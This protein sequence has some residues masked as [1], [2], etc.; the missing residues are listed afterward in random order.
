MGQGVVQQVLQGV[1]E[2]LGVDG[3]RRQIAHGVHRDL[4]APVLGPRPDRLHGRLEQCGRPLRPEPQ[5]GASVLQAG[6]VEQVV[7]HHQQPLGIV[8]GVDQQLE[9]L[10]GQRPDLLLQQQVQRQPDARQRGL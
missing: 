4:D 9:L 2:L 1:L 10:G 8:A 3:H 7:D 6:Q 5:L